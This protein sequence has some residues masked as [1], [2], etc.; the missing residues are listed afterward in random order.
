MALVSH[1]RPASRPHRHLP[2]LPA[3]CHQ[4]QVSESKQA[5]C[6][7]AENDAALPLETRGWQDA[8]QA[9]LSAVCTPRS[10][11]R[12]TGS[13]TSP[14][15]TYSPSRRCW[16]HRL[17][18]TRPKPRAPPGSHPELSP[19]LEATIWPRSPLPVPSPTSLDNSDNEDRLQ[20][21]CRT[22]EP[23]CCVAAP[24]PLGAD[25]TPTRPGRRFGAFGRERGWAAGPLSSGSPPPAPLR[26]GFCTASPPRFF[27]CCPRAVWPNPPGA[28]DRVPV[29]PGHLGGE[30]WGDTVRRE[31]VRAVAP[32]GRAAR[33]YSAQRPLPGTRLR[34]SPS[35]AH[36]CCPCQI[37]CRCLCRDLLLLLASLTQPPGHVVPARPTPLAQRPTALPHESSTFHGSPSYSPVRTA[38]SSER[39]KQ[40]SLPRPLPCG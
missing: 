34:A 39:Q 17:T 36:R 37:G 13:V 4:P 2:G 28:Q 25:P 14:V 12:R 27:L 5:L 33:P 19:A 35:P 11:W 7:H 9:A 24:H 16:E 32:G 18:P 10:R 6:T 20:S 30:L 29:V 21:C 31:E 22:A 3:R 40:V 15:G 26:F 23:S 8:P 38:K 1:P